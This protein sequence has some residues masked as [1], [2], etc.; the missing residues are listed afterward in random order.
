MFEKIPKL[1]HHYVDENGRILNM[2]TG[3]ILKP[4]KSKQGYLYVRVCEDN[5]RSHLAVHR[6]VG[7]CFVKGYKEE[8]VIEHKDGNKQNNNYKNLIWCTQKENLRRGYERRKDT[9]LRNYIPCEVYHKGEYIDTLISV[10]DA[11]KFA[12][13]KYD[14]KFSMLYKHMKHKD[15][16]LKKC[17]G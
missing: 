12:S 1:K 13:E 15:V 6:A 10:S 4:Y 14:C 11:A 3:N 9:A 16:V 2:K 17:N 7:M 8:L 5:V